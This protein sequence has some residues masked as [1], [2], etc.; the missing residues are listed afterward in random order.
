[1]VLL[2]SHIFANVAYF[3]LKAI[4]CRSFSAFCRENVRFGGAG[5]GYLSVSDACG[6]K[7]STFWVH[8]FVDAQGAGL[9][10]RSDELSRPVAPS[11]FAQAFFVCVPARQVPMFLVSLCGLMEPFRS[12]PKPIKVSY[13]PSF[14]F[15]KSVNENLEIGR[16][17]IIFAYG[18]AGLCTACVAP[19][20]C[21]LLSAS[22]E[23][24]I[25]TYSAAG[26]YM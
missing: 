23:A 5:R 17:C 24:P 14:D 15:I 12:R 18:K 8:P 26:M 10:R 4:I 19:L 13:F 21:C 25:C 1:M 22:Y 3:V 6:R 20:F 11:W 9:A 16:K 7:G 2:S